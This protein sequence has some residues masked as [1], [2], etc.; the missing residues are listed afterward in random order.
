LQS[1][2]A[3]EWLEKTQDKPL[4]EIQAE[5]SATAEGSSS[6]TG[7]AGDT[8]QSWVCNECGKKFRNMTA[9]QVHGE[10]SGHSDFAESTEEIAPLTEEEKKAKLEELRLKLAEK[11]SGMSEQDK[12][13]KKK[14]EVRDRT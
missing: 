8:A 6:A 10:R 12:A 3:L 2:G 1:K 13:D 14:N 5:E 9:V 7:G 11:R 4:D